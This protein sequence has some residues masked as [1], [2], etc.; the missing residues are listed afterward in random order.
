MDGGLIR[1]YQAAVAGEAGGRP[2]EVS[3]AKGGGEGVGTD[4]GWGGHEPIF[5]GLARPLLPSS[6]S[7]PIWIGQIGKAA[8]APS[9]GGDQ[10]AQLLDFGD[11]RRQNLLQ[12][13]RLLGGELEATVTV[14]LLR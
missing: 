12:L 7:F 13:T 3:G 11:E 4:E 10:F 1:G 5:F 9:S 14:E 8:V 6:G 2:L